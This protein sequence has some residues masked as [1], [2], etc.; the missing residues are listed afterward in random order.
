MQAFARCCNSSATLIAVFTSVLAILADSPCSQTPDSFRAPADGFIRA[1]A[2]QTDGK[3]LAGGTF[4]RRGWPEAHRHSAIQSD[5]GSL[6]PRSFSANLMIQ[7]T[8]HRARKGLVR[9]SHGTVFTVG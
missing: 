8:S 4:T 3:I 1:L 7:A 5:P 2:I 9:C 6:R